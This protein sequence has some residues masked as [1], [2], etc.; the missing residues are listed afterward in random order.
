MNC[1]DWMY[2]FDWESRNGALKATHALEIPFAF[3]NLGKSGVGIFLGPGDIPQ[4]VADKMHQ[5]WID[6]IVD[7]DPGWPKYTTDDRINMRFDTE[8]EAVTDPDTAIRSVWE[9]IR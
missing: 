3:D 7:G 6:F 1:S 5:C 8:S 4:N 9:G 2:R